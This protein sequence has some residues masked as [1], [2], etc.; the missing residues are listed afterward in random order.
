MQCDWLKD[1]HI[2][3]AR[4]IGVF[5]ETFARTLWKLSS[6]VVNCKDEIVAAGGHLTSHG[7]KTKTSRP[8]SEMERQVVLMVPIKRLDAACLKSLDF[9]FA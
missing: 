4:P 1:K 7:G 8:G 9:S 6:E 3:Q 5:P 2:T